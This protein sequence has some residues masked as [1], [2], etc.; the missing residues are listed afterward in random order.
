[1]DTITWKHDE[2]IVAL[3]RKHR[4]DMANVKL[5]IDKLQAEDAKLRGREQADKRPA[6][7]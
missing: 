3:S 2:D 5:D 1:M 4:D 6:K 7:A